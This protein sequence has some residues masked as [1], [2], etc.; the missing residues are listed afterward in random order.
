MS[1]VTQYT[2]S[3]RELVEILVKQQGLH[4]GIWG[5]YVRFGLGASNVGESPTQIH[6]AAVVPI[7]E[8]GLQKFDKETSIS[9]DAAKVNP[10]SQQ[11]TT[12]KQ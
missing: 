6:P 9:V 10:K 8:L 2:F 4:E 1:E 12:L 11:Q 7:I 3:H 5:L